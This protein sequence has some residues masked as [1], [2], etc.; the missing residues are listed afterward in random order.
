MEVSNDFCLIRVGLRTDKLFQLGWNQKQKKL[1]VD[2]LLYLKKVY[3]R[4]NESKCGERTKFWG[5]EHAVS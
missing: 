3:S 4:C 1:M 5:E 2:I